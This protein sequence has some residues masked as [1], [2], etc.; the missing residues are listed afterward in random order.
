MPA[1]PPPTTTTLRLFSDRLIPET[2]SRPTAAF[3]EHMI[4]LP[5]TVWLSMQRR[6]P[7]Q[8]RTSSSLPEAAFKG[9]SGSAIR[10]LP[11]AMKSTWPSWSAFSPSSGETRPA[12]IIGMLTAFFK[13]SM[14]GSSPPEASAVGG[15]ICGMT[16]HSMAAISSASAPASSAMPATCCAS[17]K[18][19]PAPGP[20]SMALTLQRR[21]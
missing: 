20:S 19:S 15:G 8:G 4:P 16:P 12:A 3:T 1:G 2:A 21:G 18:V 11:M 14:K 6:H 10:A 13:P 17:S 5:L 9:S 7:M